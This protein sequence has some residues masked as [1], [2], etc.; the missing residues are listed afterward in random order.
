MAKFVDAA[1]LFEPIQ[2]QPSDVDI[3]L[4]R[5]TLTPILL[6]IPFNEVE[7]RII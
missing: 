3:T 1:N 2:G 7:T 5:E 6:Q 4:I